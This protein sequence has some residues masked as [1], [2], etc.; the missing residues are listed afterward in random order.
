MQRIIIN[1]DDLGLN[2][3]INAAILNLIQKGNVTH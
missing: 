1:A 2:C 3:P